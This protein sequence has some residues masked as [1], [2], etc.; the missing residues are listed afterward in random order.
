MLKELS[1]VQVPKFLYYVPAKWRVTY[2]SSL[3]LIDILAC[4]SKVDRPKDISAHLNHIGVR[5]L[6]VK[7]QKLTDSDLDL[8]VKSKLNPSWKNVNKSKPVIAYFSI[9][10]VI[11]LR[12]I[13][14]TFCR[15]RVIV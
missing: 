13:F 9:R 14:L 7:R 6:F 11:F 10:R 3:K 15:C 2:H 4:W 12:L 5:C 8:E 1:F